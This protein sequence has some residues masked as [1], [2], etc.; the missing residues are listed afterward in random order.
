MSWLI[1]I[2]DNDS[3]EIKSHKHG[4]YLNDMMDEVRKAAEK[5]VTAEEGESCDWKK[6]S[7]RVYLLEH[8][9]RD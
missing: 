1:N 6:V 3:K 8:P 7:I 9:Y 5:I 2:E 4:Q